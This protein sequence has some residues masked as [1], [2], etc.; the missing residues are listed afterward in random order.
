MTLRARFSFRRVASIKGAYVGLGIVRPTRK[1]LILEDFTR[2]SFKL[3]DLAGIP[4]NS[5]I[6]K[7]RKQEGGFN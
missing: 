6:P 3:K 5:M 4:S 2:N 7:D 1:S